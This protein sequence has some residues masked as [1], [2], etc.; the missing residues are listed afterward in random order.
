MV[1]TTHLAG[2]SAAGGR[3]TIR[4]LLLAGLAGQAVFEIVALVLMPGLFGMPLMPAALVV[5]LG[6]TVLGLQLPMLAGWAGHLAAGIVLFPL[7]YLALRRATG[8]S[9]VAAGAAWGVALWL[10]AQGV[11][12]PLAGRPFML[13]FVPCPWAS[14]GA[15]LAYTLSVAVAFD[16]LARR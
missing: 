4:A 16:R 8:W 14:L 15:H 2:L 7:G 3:G 12:A 5:T 6:Q 1:R 10:M 11:L 13:G 9:A